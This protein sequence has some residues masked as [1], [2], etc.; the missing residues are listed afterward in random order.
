MA[1]I[2]QFK[3]HFYHRQQGLPVLSPG[4]PWP[5]ATYGAKGSEI[6]I[7]AI[8]KTHKHALKIPIQH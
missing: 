3:Q 6:Q 5:A 4:M 1:E 2:R 7:Q 8:R